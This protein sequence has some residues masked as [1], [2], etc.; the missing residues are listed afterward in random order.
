MGKKEY[1]QKNEEFLK[2]KALEE[3]VENLKGGVLFKKL[4][5]GEGRGTVRARSIVTCHYRGS[6]INGYVFDDSWQRG[7]PEAFRVSDLIEGFQTAL[8]NMHIGDRAI[9]YIPYQVGYG[10]RSDGDIPGCSVL[11]FEIELISIA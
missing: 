11:V 2:I 8:Q 9:A 1:R 10:T 3:G 4:S 6:L 7:C 5:E